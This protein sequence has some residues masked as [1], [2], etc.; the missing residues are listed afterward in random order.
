MMRVVPV[1]LRTSSS[2]CS[3]VSPAA[4][5]DAASEAGQLS[6]SVA[7][8]RIEPLGKIAWL[9]LTL[10][11]GGAVDL[12]PKFHEVVRRLRVLRYVAVDLL[13]GPIVVI[14]D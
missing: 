6:G 14:F 1:S 2:V 9:R 10:L 12:P 7:A 8:T 3:T 13:K 4:C 11:T 5:S